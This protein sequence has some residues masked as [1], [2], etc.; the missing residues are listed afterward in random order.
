MVLLYILLE[1]IA[2]SKIT[3]NCGKIGERGIK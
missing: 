3:L 1:V 2:R